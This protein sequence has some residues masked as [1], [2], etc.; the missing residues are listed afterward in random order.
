M[1]ADKFNGGGHKSA[2][3]FTIASE[4]DFVD[5]INELKKLINN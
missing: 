4:S 2:S 3:G 5:V 1:I